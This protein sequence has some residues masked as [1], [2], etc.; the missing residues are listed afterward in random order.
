MVPAM[1]LIPWLVLPPVAVVLIA[2][3]IANRTPVTVSL[4]PVPLEFR[5]PLFLVL[6]GGIGLGILVGGIAT[7]LRQSKW[8]R[9]ARERRRAHDALQRELA[10]VG[11]ALPAKR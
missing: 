7:W 5:L 10:Q 3:A 1:R 2:F 4:D 8:R 11:S 6:L 9:L